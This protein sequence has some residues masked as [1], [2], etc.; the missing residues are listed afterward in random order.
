MFG[1]LRVRISNGCAPLAEQFW[2][3][4]AVIVSKF[5]KSSSHYAAFL[6]SLI[7]R[8]FVLALPSGQSSAA[9][10]VNVTG[11]WTLFESLCKDLVIFTVRLTADICY[12]LETFFA[13]FAVAF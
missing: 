13:L 10:Q 1:K 3:F 8:I 4:A 11:I 9:A 7:H 2:W 5:W 12:C 6:Y